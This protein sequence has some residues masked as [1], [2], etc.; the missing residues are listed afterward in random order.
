MFIS[1]CRDIERCLD[2]PGLLIYTV[3]RTTF[4]PNYLS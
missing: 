4:Q 2:E 1:R 3:T